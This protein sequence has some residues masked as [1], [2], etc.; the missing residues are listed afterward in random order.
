MAEANL[1]GFARV[2]EIVTTAV[3]ETTGFTIAPID[4]VSE[5][6]ESAMEYMGFRDEV[7]E[8]AADVMDYVGGRPHEVQAHHRRRL[9][10]QSRIALI[11]D[12]TAAAEA[13]LRA[14]FAFGK[15]ISKPQ[16]K[17]D[18]VQAII[19][20]AWDDPNNQRKLTSYEA[21]RHRS[22]E[23][24]TAANLFPTLFKGNGKVRVGFRDAD[25]VTDVVCDPEDDETPLWYVVRKR[26]TEW[27]FE[28]HMQEPILN[29]DFENGR[30]KVWYL[31]HWRNV[32]DLEQWARDF[33]GKAPPRPK[34]KDI[35][36]GEAEHFRINRIGRSQ[37]GV[38]PWAR[39]LRFYTALNQLT[40]AQVQMRQGAATIIAQ[41]IR[42]G[43][44][45]AL[46]KSVTS[47]MARAGEIGA[48]RGSFGGPP[49]AAGPGT[50][51]TAGQ[52]PPPAGAWA[53]GFEHDRLEA[54]NLR[55]GAGEA[56]QDAQIVRA[57]IA[58]A[59]GF[60]QHYLGDASSTNLAAATTLELPT[61][62]EVSAWQETFEGL[63]RWFTDR[64]IEEAVHAGLLGGQI[65][66]EET[67]DTRSLQEVKITED[68]AELEARTG[69]DL[70]YTFQMPYPG[71]R[72]LPDVTA[73]VGATLM[74]LDPGGDNWPLRELMVDF[75]MRNGFDVEDPGA[76]VEEIIENAKA[77]Q[78]KREA[79]EEEQK[80]WG[81][82]RE[83]EATAPE[84]GGGSPVPAASKGTPSK[85]GRESEDASPAGNGAKMRSRPAS[86]EMGKGT[87]TREV[88]HEAAAS[89]KEYDPHALLTALEADARESWERTMSDPGAFTANGSHG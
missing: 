48:R 53:N 67:L 83:V 22:N 35:L 84:G 70:T 24:L 34:D 6:R 77:A 31:K 15:G 9:A 13:T 71:R 20:A 11:H 4:E 47:V 37:F 66:E 59:S 27:N 1:T 36:P 60:G 39:T 87:R 3:Q 76:L 58:A 65:A 10:Q 54:V 61:L 74:T 16:A 17:D 19:D 33:G 85:T 57:P 68:R 21:Q 38:P 79:E 28:T 73:A 64:V 72:N 49:A 46:M 62:M 86:N 18:D 2:R 12:P 44:P 7:E 82:E 50:N 32:A 25:D 14:N 88:L 51:P 5:L 40:E 42:K 23:M 80:Q 30:Q 29:L 63:Y 41:R 78:A 52:P 45:G 81:R 26:R 69:K 89:G 8:M 43:G 75:L 55:S 56:L